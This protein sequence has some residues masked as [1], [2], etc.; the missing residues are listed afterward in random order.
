MSKILMPGEKT[1]LPDG[2][3]VEFMEVNID[4]MDDD[5][6]G[7]EFHN[8]SCALLHDYIGLCGIGRPDGKFGIFVK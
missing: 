7:C 6:E 5:C 1:T 3:T 2:R 8:E 4:A